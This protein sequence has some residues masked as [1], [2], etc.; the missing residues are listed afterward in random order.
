VVQV[1]FDQD[2]AGQC[3]RGW[4]EG[5]VDRET[6]WEFKSLAGLALASRLSRAGLDRSLSPISELS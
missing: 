1:I 3:R 2:N 6:I 5:A 4:D